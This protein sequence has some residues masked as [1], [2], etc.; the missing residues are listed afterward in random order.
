MSVP[1]CPQVG[2]AIN[3]MRWSVLTRVLECEV[4]QSG[5]VMNGDAFPRG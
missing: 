2:E 1:L 4:R 5:A 3:A